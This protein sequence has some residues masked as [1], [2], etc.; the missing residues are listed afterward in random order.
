LKYDLTGW[1]K[2]INW[3]RELKNMSRS[4]G[5][6]SKKK[7]ETKRQLVENYI[8]KAKLFEKKVTSES[9]LFQLKDNKDLSLQIELEYY[10]KMLNKHIDL[11]ERRVL[12]KEIIPH[13]EKVFSIF[14]PYTEW[15]TKG[16]LNPAFELGKNI[17][18]TSDQ[19]HLIISHK[20]M[21]N[22]KDSQV[23]IK[24]VDSLLS[25]YKI[26]S[27]SFDKGFYSTE[28]K[29]LIKLFIPELIMPKK[30]KLN[31]EQYIE[32]HE[33]PYKK[34]RNKHSAVE[35]N[36]NELE[37]RGLDKCPDRSYA[38]FK[39]YIALGIC[40]Y[41]LHKIGSELLRQKQ[42]AEKLLIAA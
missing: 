32:E 36:I 33:K 17:L 11:L 10:L 15:I 3:K 42:E 24:H 14:E 16:K 35:S 13:E 26:Q 23:V 5:Q 29:E 19:Y 39:N 6:A 30:G 7:E 1:R 22:E 41:N 4:V 38:H 37:H 18:I 31:K 21:E 20:V 28:N 27:W 9:K 40:A 12:R 25:K 2:L 34:L 8:N